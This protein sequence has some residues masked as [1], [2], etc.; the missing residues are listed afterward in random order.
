MRGSWVAVCEGD[1][2]S[3]DSEGMLHLCSFS[4]IE[5]DRGRSVFSLL[6]NH[7]CPTENN[8]KHSIPLPHLGFVSLREIS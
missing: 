1:E 6:S 3:K 4:F 2:K 5:G 8:L 7:R